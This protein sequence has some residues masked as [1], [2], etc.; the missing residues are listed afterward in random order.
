MSIFW[1]KNSKRNTVFNAVVNTAILKYDVLVTATLPDERTYRK[2]HFVG[3]LRPRATP[4][5][6]GEADRGRWQTR[7]PFPAR[8]SAAD[9]ASGGRLIGPLLKTD[10]WGDPPVLFSRIFLFPPRV[11]YDKRFFN[12][13]QLQFVT[14]F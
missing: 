5:F 4:S 10:T 11:G 13:P 14:A 8:K 6:P 2:V 12:V 9:V 7:A 3:F 1:Y